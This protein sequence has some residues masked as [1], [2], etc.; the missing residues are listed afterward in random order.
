MKHPYCII[1]VLF[2]AVKAEN[3]QAWVIAY[4]YNTHC[5]CGV[6]WGVCVSV[7]LSVFI[8]GDGK[9]HAS[10]T[11][12]VVVTWKNKFA[13]V[14]VSDAFKVKCG[15]TCCCFEMVGSMLLKFGG[16]VSREYH[17]YVLLGLVAQ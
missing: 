9:S 2:L 16:W 12:W 15:V 4:Y 5:R 8:L 10:E 1:A 3:R 14:W 13:F 7:C 11:W 6:C 17:A